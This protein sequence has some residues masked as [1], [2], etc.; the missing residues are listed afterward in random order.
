MEYIRRHINPGSFGDHLYSG[1]LFFFRLKA[2]N[3]N[4]QSLFLRYRAGRLADPLADG[5]CAGQRSNERCV[6]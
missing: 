6:F 1:A 3:Q 4:A 2:R 5:G